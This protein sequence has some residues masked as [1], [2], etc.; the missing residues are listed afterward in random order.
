MDNL[1]N[2]ISTFLYFDKWITLNLQVSLIKI[3]K[4]EKVPLKLCQI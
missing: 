2:Q 3:V 1:F 4:K